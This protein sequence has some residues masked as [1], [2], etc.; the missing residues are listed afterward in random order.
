MLKALIAKRTREFP[1][2]IHNLARLAEV[3]A[4]ELSNERARLLRELSRYYTQ[5]RYP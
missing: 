2:R 1:P 5:A 4:L 3:A